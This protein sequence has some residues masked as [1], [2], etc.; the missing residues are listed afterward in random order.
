MV[1]VVGDMEF[2]RNLKNEI[3]DYLSGTLKLTL[4]QEKTKITNLN[5]NH[6]HYLGA[7]IGIPKPTESKIVTR[8]MADGRK[9]VSRVNHTRV[10]FYAP[11]NRIYEDLYKAGFTNNIKPGIPNAITK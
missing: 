10:Y 5:T 3:S 8:K 6:A 9:I 7:E 2:A 11:I 4:S 1:G